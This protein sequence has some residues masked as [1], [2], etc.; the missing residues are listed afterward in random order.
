MLVGAEPELGR[1]WLQ[2]SAWR[3]GYGEFRFGHQYVGED[4]EQDEDGKDSEP[5][6]AHLVPHKQ[7]GRGFESPDPA[8]ASHRAGAWRGLGTH[9]RPILGSSTPSSRS[10]RRLARITATETS[11]KRPCSSG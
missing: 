4:G 5:R 9:A 1:W 8:R 11:R 2:G 6:H 3:V 10:A 7:P